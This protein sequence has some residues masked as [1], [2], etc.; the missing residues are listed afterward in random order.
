M[1][2][3][4]ANSPSLFAIGTIA[5][6]PAR[7]TIKARLLLTL[8][9]LMTM[10]LLSAKTIVKTRFDWP[11]GTTLRVERTH[12]N[13]K[14]LFVSRY[15]IRLEEK[16]DGIFRFTLGEYQQSDGEGEYKNITGMYQS[17]S[18]RED[19]SA[20]DA[21]TEGG[22]L[23]LLSGRV[24]REIRKNLNSRLYRQWNVWVKNWIGL[25]LE[26][27]VLA[28]DSTSAKIGTI[29]K[30]HGKRAHKLVEI[31]SPD[32][33]KVITVTKFSGN[34]TSDVFR[35]TIK[36]GPS[37]VDIDKAEV[38]YMQI[39]TT[40]PNT[41]VPVDVRIERNMTF[42]NKNKKQVKKQTKW[43]RYTF[44]PIEN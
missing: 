14:T 35:E 9:L 39:I 24:R 28:V 40:N 19:G 38:N 10:T 26:K 13:G 23:E 11:V 29:G 6:E 44:E 2:E 27:N 5:M 22:E 30:I 17:M 21:K 25:T 43:T 8:V 12:F 42:Y 33:I 20:F 1:I 36:S 32:K 7:I 18:V 15:V 37:T 3:L 16:E 31:Y 41:L 34:E 4:S